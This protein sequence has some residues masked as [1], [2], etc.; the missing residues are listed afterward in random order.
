M[1]ISID[2]QK[3]FGERQHPFASWASGQGDNALN[4]WEEATVSLLTALIT[5]EIQ[6]VH[7]EAGNRAKCTQTEKDT[8]RENTLTYGGNATEPER[9]LELVLQFSELARCNIKSK[10]LSYFSTLT[11]YNWE[12]FSKI[13]T[14]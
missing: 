1:T 4:A 10:C 6:P 8:G 2:A 5:L 7:S 3:A 14:V 12:N 9:L 13:L 11:T